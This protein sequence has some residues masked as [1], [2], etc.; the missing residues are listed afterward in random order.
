MKNLTQTDT[1]EKV[2]RYSLA[3]AIISTVGL[4]VVVLLAS[5]GV[6]ETSSGY[7]EYSYSPILNTWGSLQSTFS[8]LLGFSWGIIILILFVIPRKKAEKE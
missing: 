7:D 3:V 5:W 1:I 8:Y 2:R 4:L 6:I